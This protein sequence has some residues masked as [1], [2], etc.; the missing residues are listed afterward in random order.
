MSFNKNTKKNYLLDKNYGPIG[1]NSSNSSYYNEAIPNY[2]TRIDVDNIITASGMKPGV[3]DTNAQIVIGRDRWPEDTIPGKKEAIHANKNTPKNS[4]YSDYHG[5]GAIDLV[6]GRMAPFPVEISN[7]PSEI[8]PL[9]TSAMTKN[10]EVVTQTLANGDYHT[11]IIMDAARIYV[12]QMCDIDQYF[13]LTKVSD[14]NANNGPCSGIILKADKL[15]LHSRRDVYIHAG[16]D[17]EVPGFNIDSCGATLLD[18]PKIHLMVGNGTLT[19]EGFIAVTTN[20]GGQ[21]TPGGPRNTFETTRG[22]RYNAMTAPKKAQQPI[23][24]GENLVEC[25]DQMCQIMKDSFE[26]INNFIISQNELNGLIANHVHGT[27]VGMT[28]QDPIMQIKYVQTA[29][30]S[31]RGMLSAF[32]TVYNNIPALKL[33]YLDKEGYR[34]IN[35]RHVTVT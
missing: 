20:T 24:R 33:N 35:S 22:E 32:Q 18:K 8:S 1:Q 19:E 11:G 7:G 26:Q 5:A 4:G 12:S 2:A 9:Y 14:L 34:Y 13:K 30:D 27:G 16:G 29:I 17:A 31:I 3:S 15:R 25:L 21:S 10:P 23:P 6:V 28:T